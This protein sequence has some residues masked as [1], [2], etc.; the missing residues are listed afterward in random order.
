M[1]TADLDEKQQTVTRW[2]VE[3]AVFV[4]WN[5]FVKHKTVDRNNNRDLIQWIAGQIITGKREIQQSYLMSLLC[6]LNDGRNY[7]IRYNE[8]SILTVL[9]DAAEVL[10][11]LIKDIKPPLY[12][13]GQDFLKAMR[14]EAVY[15]CCR[16]NN[17]D[18]A[19]EVFNRQFSSSADKGA[20][21]KEHN[22]Q[23]IQKMLKTK[24]PQ[25]HL[26]TS[27]EYDDFLLKAQNFLKHFVNTG[28]P[29]LLKMAESRQ[30]HTTADPICR[31]KRV[32]LGSLMKVCD[33]M[34]VSKESSWPNFMEQR[35]LK[36]H[37]QQVNQE[38]KKQSNTNIN[39]NAAS[40]PTKEC[41]PKKRKHA[42]VDESRMDTSL[43]SRVQENSNLN[44]YVIL[45]AELPQLQTKLNEKSPTKSLP[46]PG[47]LRNPWLEAEV[48]EFY[49]AVQIFG[50]GNWSRI[51]NAMRTYRT[52]VQL[53]D[54]WRTILK[55]GEINRLKKLFGDVKK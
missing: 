21:D 53:K 54:K 51:K 47:K 15:V 1:S 24:N 17:F 32:N 44:P 10:Q 3:Y 48:N 30:D 45:N 39:A 40:T 22:K 19:K 55:T 26:L 33:E 20:E 18:D 31:D 23:E 52:N 41:S 37:L 27:H 38:K 2:I 11:I 46:S 25:H 28:K 29:S 36:E 5:D 34:G 42:A 7:M 8:D 13:E 50:I 12:K 16:A 4:V 9:E 43:A 49:Q 6:R 35:A 14:Q